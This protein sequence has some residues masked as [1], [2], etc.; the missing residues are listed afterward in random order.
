MTGSFEV[1][2]PGMLTTVQDLG[3]HGH[4]SQGVPVSGAMDTFALQVGNLLLGNDPGAAGLE[5]A[6][7]GPVLRCLRGIEVCVCG[8]DLGA[9]CSGD[10]VPLWRPFRVRPGDDISFAGQRLGV[11]AYLCV[12]A[13][14][15]VPLVLGSRSTYLRAGLGG[16]D[17]RQLR[18][19]DVIAT[20]PAGPGGPGRPLPS[21]DVPA[22]AARAEARAVPG[23]QDSLFDPGAL[24]MLFS[25]QFTVSTQSDRMGYRLQR[26]ADAPG[27]RG[28]RRSST[29]AEIPSAGTALGSIQVLPDGDPIV[30]M[31]DRQT[32]GGYPQIAT[33]ISVDVARIA[34]LPPGG[35]VAFR[36]VTVEEAQEAARRQA[37]L[38]ARLA[39]RGDGPPP[40]L[41]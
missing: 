13:G 2:S 41:P 7:H 25:A 39:R 20:L 40:N 22:L 21:A 19:G 1:L 24:E 38:V 26:A 33:V 34:Q 18:A 5:I 6:L 27:G 16:L 3:R 14:I 29:R 28:P 15:D 23:P 35:T 30:L 37:G 12:E 17:G 8:A 10:P 9:Q 31:A 36:P 32:T 4:Q 11:W